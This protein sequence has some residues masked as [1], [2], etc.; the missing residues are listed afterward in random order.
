MPLIVRI[1]N[2]FGVIVDKFRYQES[3]YINQFKLNDIPSIAFFDT[4]EVLKGLV[5]HGILSCNKGYY[6]FNTPYT[7]LII[8]KIK[9]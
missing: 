5:Q 2:L 8:E 3:Y 7:R 6:T 4:K 1:G 9:K